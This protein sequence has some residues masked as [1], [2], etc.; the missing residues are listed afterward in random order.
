MPDG[1][2]LV[3]VVGASGVGK[4]S[5]LDGARVIFS[6]DSRVVFVR[7]VITRPTG[8]GGEDH[9]AATPE[10]F[11]AHAFAIHWTANGLA[12][13]LPRR[14]DDDLAAG[15]LVVANVS[16]QVLD[17]ARRRYPGLTVCE[18]T[19]SAPA[20]RARLAARGRE[21]PAEIEARLARVGAPTVG[22]D[23]VSIANDGA[24]AD[25]VAAF[26]RLIDQLLP[27]SA[28]PAT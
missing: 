27:A 7:R 28:K 24:L 13:G 3:L 5:V 16:R 4:D 8:S 17:E 26:V 1:R 6:A 11:A 20:L 18:V 19:A 22:H 21:S 14:M 23:V 25:A 15:R 9:I 10:E 12:Y 2:R